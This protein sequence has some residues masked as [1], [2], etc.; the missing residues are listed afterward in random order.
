[1]EQPKMSDLQSKLAGDA[2]PSSAAEELRQAMQDML[3]QDNHQVKGLA[4]QSK[5]QLAREVVH[6][7]A[8]MGQPFPY[9]S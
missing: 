6:L 7:R 2:Q 1:M 9:W 4:A 5:K 8:M 3:D